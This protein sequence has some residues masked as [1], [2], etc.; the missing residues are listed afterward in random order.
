M[1]KRAR[2]REIRD[3]Y[4]RLIDESLAYSGI[5]PKQRKRLLPKVVYIISELV[6]EMLVPPIYPKEK[7]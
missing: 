1:G 4:D 7:P 2:R 5:P 3:K 6:A